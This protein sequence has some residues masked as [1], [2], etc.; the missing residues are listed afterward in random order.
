MSKTTNWTDEEIQFLKDN[1]FKMTLNQIACLLDKNFYQVKTKSQDLRLIKN[2]I[3]YWTSDEKKYLLDNYKIKTIKDMSIK[4]E[5]S[6]GSVK[7]KIKEMGLVPDTL[8]R[9]DQTKKINT[10]RKSIIF[11]HD[12]STDI[13]LQIKNRRDLEKNKQLSIKKRNSVLNYNYL[14]DFK[15]MNKETAYVLGFIFGDGWISKPNSKHYQ[16]MV[17]NQINDA[18]PYLEP[19]FTKMSK[20]QSRYIFDKTGTRKDQLRFTIS[21]KELVNFLNE[22]LDL[23][24]KNN[25]FSQKLIDFIPEHL[26]QYLLRGLFDADGGVYFIRNSLE[27][28]ITSNYDFDWTNLISLIQRYLDIDINLIK[29]EMKKSQSLGSRIKISKISSC[30]KFLNFIYKDFDIDQLGFKRKYN[31]FNN[32]LSYREQ[33]PYYN[34]MTKNSD[35]IGV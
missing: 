4:L 8:K 14:D 20:W 17:K 12:D 1:R 2:K 13:E 28:D 5:R 31:K 27:C 25:Y 9:R 19:I 22:D 23:K 35:L 18:L 33:S 10:E 24:N 29:F 7:S 16:V 26:H 3:I 30:C 32:Y 15:I 11:D 21:N 6:F 34:T